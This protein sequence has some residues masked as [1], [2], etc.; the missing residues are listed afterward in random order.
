MKESNKKIF[1][2]AGEA[3]GDLN[4]Q[5]L[6]HEIKNII[7]GV[8]ISGI[9]GEKLRSEGV[10]ITTDY[11]EV[12]FIGF[13]AVLKNY[14]ALKAILNST[15]NYIKE[16]N[17]E[18]VILVDFPGFNLKLAELLRKFYTGKIIYYISPQLWA[19]HKGRVKQVR[20]Y[21]DRMLVVFP[22]EKSFY[23]DENI[24]AD[25]VGHPLVER[26]SRF[27]AENRKGNFA[28]PQIGILPGSRKE[29]VERILPV[30]AETAKKLQGELNADIN[31]VASSNIDKTLYSSLLAGYNFNIV[32]NTEGSNLNYKI[33]LNSDLLFTKS[34][35]STVECALIGSPFCVVYKAGK[36][37]YVIGKSLIKVKFIAMVN[38][39]AGREIV[40]EFIQNDMT[41]ENL[42]AEGRRIL[43]DKDYSKSIKAGLKDVRSILTDKPASRNAAEIIA[44]YLR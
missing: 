6:V 40:K 26:V 33:I 3:S 10:S 21:I 28:S 7:P 2:V 9:G 1:I 44:E 24:N 14:P 38:L 19:W 12:N 43:T 34:G 17:P 13:T 31:V 23:K 16:L 41:V 42:Y 30:L 22:F 27:L 5:A 39:L 36:L 20:K 35:T 15:V 4:A 25:F 11:K 32:T 29:E 8:Q 37:N 18:V